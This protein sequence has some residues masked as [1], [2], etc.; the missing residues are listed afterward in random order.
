MLPKVEVK[1]DETLFCAIRLSKAGFGTVQQILDSD[2]YQVCALL[3]FDIFSHK[4]EE[5]F[6]EMNRKKS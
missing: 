2:V 5:A 6:I 4:Y 1:M 3:D